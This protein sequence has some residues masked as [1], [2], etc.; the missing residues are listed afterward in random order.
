MKLS[1]TPDY[2]CN[3]LT[4]SILCLLG[5]VGEVNGNGKMVI[6]GNLVRVS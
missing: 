2:Y 1:F 6:S 3:F 5:D 4:L